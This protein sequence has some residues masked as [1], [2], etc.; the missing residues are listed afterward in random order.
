MA[1]IRPET[2]VRRGSDR[3]VGVAGWSTAAEQ[4]FHAARES[5]SRGGEGVHENAVSEDAS[6]AETVGQIAAPQSAK[7][8]DQRWNSEEI[9]GPIAVFRRAWAEMPELGEG[10]LQDQR[11]TSTTYV[12]KRKL[13]AATAQNSPLD[14][15]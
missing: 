15:I 6:S 2:R 4:P 5:G 10:G 1:A 9:P 14:G 8:A 11:P 7:A 13:M 12:S 3:R